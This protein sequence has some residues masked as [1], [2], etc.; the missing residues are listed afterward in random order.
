MNSDRTNNRDPFNNATPQRPSDPIAR[1]PK[2]ADPAAGGMQPAEVSRSRQG[3]QD[4]SNLAKVVDLLQARE[5]RGTLP[6]LAS[7]VAPSAGASLWPHQP[8]QTPPSMTELLRSMLHFKWSMITILL[9]ISLPIIALV[10]TQTTA[11]Y[12]AKAEIRVRPI[13]PRLVFKTD[14]NGMIPLYD[15]FVNTQIPLIKSLTVLQR[16]LD[17]KDVQATTWY[18]NRPRT[19]LERITADKTPPLERLRDALSAQPRPRTEI[20]DVGL[21]APTA[22]EAKQIVDAVLDSYIAYIGEKA[23][24]TEDKL[25]RQL[26]DQYK[27]LETEIQGRE[28]VC[29]ELHKSLGTETP[30]E[31]VSTKRVR[32][33]QLQTRLKELRDARALLEWQMNQDGNTPPVPGMDP[34]ATTSAEKQ[35]RYY[36]DA[37]WRRLDTEVKTIQHQID[38]SRYT[39]EHPDRIRLEADLKFAQDLRRQRETQ[40]SEQWNDQVDTSLGLAITT[41][42]VGDPDRNRRDAGS[43]EHQLARA[44]QEEQLLQTEFEKQQAE[45]KALFESAQ[46]LEKQNAELKSKRDL[47]AAVQERLNQKNM[48]RNVPGSI[49][50]LTRAYASS[51]PTKDRRVVFTIM[52][53]LAGLGVSGGITFLRASR[54]QVVYA[55]Q[56]MP[57]AMRA[58]FLGNVPL[59]HGP[60]LQ[61]GPLAATIDEPDRSILNESIR[62]ARTALLSRLDMQNTTSIQVTSSSPGTGKSSF[63]LMLGKSLAQAGKKVLM[64]DADFYK[65]TLSRWC[66]VLETPGFIESLDHHRVD[67]GCVIATETP[68]LSV[69]SAGRQGD[70]AK[71]AEELANGALKACMSQLTRRHDYDV[72]LFDSAPMLPSADAAILAGRVDGTIMVEREHVSHRSHIAESISLLH[73]AGGHL[74]G[75]IFV[76]SIHREGYGYGYGYGYATSG[77]R[78]E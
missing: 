51:L 60:K 18:K 38:I 16:A 71:A 75:T 59:I 3:G 14:E 39:R 50:V 25:Y 2:D 30:Q 47:F 13:I 41:P 69:I 19:L 26:V 9:L 37:E 66:G 11:Q 7:S 40:L 24:A 34:S 21:S 76:G 52:A 33:D 61:G 5:A 63:T 35:P 29:S 10:W 67:E 56:D 22:K 28:K 1:N 70:V 72:I 65:M 43:L 27:S 54:N 49:E 45:F 74:L 46:L 77:E 31:F 73:S 12:Q 64:I 53:L 4:N 44:K 6:V 58:P 57:V 55:P 62:F 8:A 78:Q 23:D 20:I 48:E 68:G 42:R 15:S 36:Q 17:Q 32:L